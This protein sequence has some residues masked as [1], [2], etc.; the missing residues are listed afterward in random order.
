MV[1]E[2]VEEFV[3]IIE[4]HAVDKKYLSIGCVNK[5]TNQVIY[6]LWIKR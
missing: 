6:G 5:C 3:V 4:E 1:E 2:K